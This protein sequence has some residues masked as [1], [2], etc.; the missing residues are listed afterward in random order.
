MKLARTLQH[1]A[2]AEPSSVTDAQ[3]IAM[4]EEAMA[5][6]QS[7]KPL[8]EQIGTTSY[9]KITDRVLN[10]ASAQLIKLRQLKHP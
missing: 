9:I 7:V 6:A 3:K 5:L 2:K 4:L 8:F 10:E 1:Y